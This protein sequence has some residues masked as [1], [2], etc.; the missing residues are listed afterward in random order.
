MELRRAA[1]NGTRYEL[2]RLDAL[3]A[4]P[5]F[6]ALRRF[7]RERQVDLAALQQRIDALI[8]SAGQAAHTPPPTAGEAPA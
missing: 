5:E 1:A 7:P 8:R 6:D 4:L 2:P 3:V